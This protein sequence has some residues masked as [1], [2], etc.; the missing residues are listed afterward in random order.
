[1]TVY[2]DTSAL[3]RRYLPDE[4]AAEV[5]AVLAADATWVT[6]AVARAEVEQ[7][8]RTASTSQSEVAALRMAWLGDLDTLHLVPLD[9]RCL[10][11]AAELG[12]AFHLTLPDALH[13]AAADRLPRPLTYLTLAGSQ[14]PAALELGF[15][16]RPS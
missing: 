11:R 14:I 4:A 13:L 5:R 9:G 16:V 7:V 2:A 6:S 1:V 3:L 8:L 15:E 12:A 10:T